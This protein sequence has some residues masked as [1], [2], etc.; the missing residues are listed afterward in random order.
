[1]NR[2]GTSSEPP[3][4]PY[5]RSEPNLLSPA[6]P[7]PFLFPQPTNIPVLEMQMDVGF[8]QTE[9][10]MSDPSSRNT[11]LRPDAWRDPNEQPPASNDNASSAGPGTAGL[12]RPDAPS[13]V[14]NVASDPVQSSAANA[15]AIPADGEANPVTYANGSSVDAV[16]EL[17]S[18]DTPPQIPADAS[19][20]LPDPGVLPLPDPGVLPVAP[21]AGDVPSVPTETPSQSAATPG[22]VDVQSLLDNL[23]TSLTQGPVA[24]SAPPADGLTVATTSSFA[25]PGAEPSVPGA[26]DSQPLSA[27]GLGAPPSGLPPRPPPQEQ[28]LIHPNYAHSQHIRDYHPHAA[29]SAFQPHARTNS[30][31]NAADPASSTFASSVPTANASSEGLNPSQS[32]PTTGLVPASAGSVGAENG[33]R[34]SAVRTP[35]ESRRESKL[36]AGEIPSAD[37]RPWTADIQRKYDQFLEDERRYVN[38]ARWDQFPAGSRLFVGNL[39]SEK[40]TKRDIFHVFHHYGPLAQISIKQ[41]YGFV[42]FLHVADCNRALEGEQGRQIREKR[43]HLEVS[44]PQK[45]KGGANNKNE[46]PASRRSRSPEYGHRG[47]NSGGGNMDRYTS[48]RGGNGRGSRDEYRPGS[49]RSPSPRGYRDRYDDRYRARSRSPGYGRGGD[50]YKSSGRSPPRGSNG[51]IDDDLP[52]PPRAP[53]DVPEVQ[54]LVQAELNRDF[55]TWVEGAFTSRG[56]R[57]GTIRLSPRL[58]ESAVVRRQ[59]VEGVM[60]VVKLRRGNQDTGRIGLTIFKRRPGATGTGSGDVLFEE[61]EGLEPGICVELVLREKQSHAAAPPPPAPHGYP[62]TYGAAPAAPPY[63]YPSQPPAGAP[64]GPPY[65]YPTGYPPAAAAAPGYPGAPPPQLHGLNTNNLQSLLTSL[66]A[67]PQTASTP[68]YPPQAYG[69]Y[70]QPPP[71]PPPPQMPG[72]A[73]PGGA[74]PPNM[75]DILARLGTYGAGR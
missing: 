14:P 73:A 61:Y 1:M 36:A 58:D 43:I 63:G 24:N 22:G 6:S 19:L 5:L 69:Q 44:K 46:G 53:Q 60:A 4:E 27:S 25:P 68:G 59:I 10:H 8:N 23:Q 51:D 29:N 13:E 52:L 74:P 67:S 42:Q 41:A 38:E 45:S 12:D 9:V 62:P 55:I 39:S 17:P 33:L 3:E 26:S 37:D 30:S 47:R 16:L 50:R 48:G 31:S 65:G 57:V 71:Q 70:G 7:K 40:V 11:E 35:I 18:N 34:A 32:S 2:S 21:A 72:Q 64:A 15:Q 20:P 75:Q 56:V 49:R 54:I 28:P 66:Q